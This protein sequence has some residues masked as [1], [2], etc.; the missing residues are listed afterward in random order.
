ME[1]HQSRGVYIVEGFEFRKPDAEPMEKADGVGPPRDVR[2][3]EERRNDE[4]TRDVVDEERLLADGVPSV[5]HILYGDVVDVEQ[6]SKHE[7][8]SRQMVSP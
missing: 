3:E 1:E 4:E 7:E 6:P 2:V 8:H 5:H